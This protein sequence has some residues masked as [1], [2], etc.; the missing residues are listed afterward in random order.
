VPNEKVTAYPS[1]YETELVLKDGSSILVRPIRT[2]DIEG[3]VAFISRLSPRTKYLR[4][5]HV[6]KDMGREEAKL[7]CTVDYKNSFAFVA[8]VQKEQ[9]KDIVA[10]GRYSRAPAG[11]SAE[12]AFAIQDEYQDKGIGTK[13]VECLV[14]VALDS[15]ITVFEGDVL[16]ENRDMMGVLRSYGFHVVTDLEAGVYH[17]SFPTTRTKRVEKREYERERISS[18]ASV[19]SFL[20]PRSVA[21]IGAAK[22]QDKIGHIIF[23]CILQSGFS[24][25]AY[26]VNPKADSVLSVKAY[27]SIL[28]IPGD[29][30]LAVIAVP[31]ELVPVIAGQCG[32]KGVHTLVVISDGFKETGIEGASREKALRDITF[33]YGMRLVGPNC[34]GIINTDP[35]IAL[36]ATF[37]QTYPPRGNAAFLSQSGA[38]GMVVLEYANELNIGISAFV[39]LGNRADISINDLLQYWEQDPS[40]KV[41]LLY[42]ESF[43]NPRKFSRIARRV[44]DKKPIIAVKGGSTRAGSRAASFHTG[45]LATSNIASD[46]L[47]RQAGIIRTDSIEDLFNAATLFSNQPL[48]KG[49]R[50]GIVTNGGGPGIIAAD[51]CEKQ[52]LLV[53]ELPQETINKLK[54]YVKRDIRFN[55]PLD[56]TA[57]ATA[58]EFV[59]ALKVFAGNDSIDAVIAIFIPPVT[60]E[61]KTIEDSIRLVA[62]LFRR[63]NKPLLVCFMGQRGFK[64]SLGATGNFVPSYPFPEGAVSALAK[65][66]EYAEHR[67]KPKGSI[68]KIHG[69]YRKKART[70]I[71]TAMTKSINRPFSLSAQEVIDLL[72]CYNIRL[73]ETLVARTADEAIAA[74]SKLGFPV[75]IKLA[76]STILHKTDID[77]VRLDV[78]SAS[79]ARK[80]FGDIVS[81]VK[82]IG[83]K[84]EMDGVA[85]QR[86]VKGGIET[87]VGVTQDPSFGPLIMFGMGGIYAEMLKD[88]A[89]RLHPLTDVDASEL[90]GSI[91]MAKLF[92]GFRG[93][94]PSDVQALE[95]LLLRLS[96]MVEDMPEITDLDFNPVKVMPVGE[97]YWIV[98]AR[99]MV[100]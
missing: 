11:Y 61:T 64:I 47:F 93:A 44:S 28:D 92:D 12:I 59:N 58:E 77:A 96:A 20:F 79:E 81:R 91:K 1:Q 56:M 63:Q 72:S 65:A 71:E 27:P 10:I 2:D 30:D 7:F 5:H 42:L 69:I 36:N 6:T 14:N 15:G 19:H 45:A 48:P 37:S 4:F 76:S 60:L 50:V 21:V 53:Q 35:E 16:S 25:T 94:P 83:R 74:A 85:V 41:I 66:C 100:R 70:V 33:G 86:M 57:S 62:P 34:M 38:I 17:F 52:G 82:K 24:G 95:D 43:G 89:V 99:I 88:V 67:R 55:N 87:I 90:I 31:A 29:V 22:R 39:S 26:P 32:Q 3:W 18:I 54:T 78:R 75:A 40:T 80:A 8:E 73:T 49:R 97:G 46:A 13:L 68:P 23:K 84:D 98:D 51:A 9:H